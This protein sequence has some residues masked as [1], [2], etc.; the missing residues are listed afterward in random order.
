MKIM[1]KSFN[2]LVALAVAANVVSAQ[3][4]VGNGE[5]NNLRQVDS[6]MQQRG[7]TLFLNG[8]PKG[9]WSKQDLEQEYGEARWDIDGLTGPYRHSPVT[10]SEGETNTHRTYV[11][12]VVRSYDDDDWYYDDDE[13]KRSKK[14]P[15]NKDYEYVE[16]GDGENGKGYNT[17]DDDYYFEKG[18]KKMSKRA[19]KKAH[20]AIKKAKKEKKDKKGK[21]G[22]G[23]GSSDDECYYYDDDCMTIAEIA[24]ETEGFET[25]CGLVL[26]TGLGQALSEDILTVF[27]P[28]NDAF[29]ELGEDVLA[30]LT[31]EEVAFILQYHAVEDE[32]LS[33]DL[34]CEA[35]VEMSNGFFTETQCDDDGYIYQVGTGNTNSNR[36]L[37]VQVDIDACN[38]VVHV[39]D[40]VILPDPDEDYTRRKLP[41]YDDDD[42]YRKDSKGSKSGKSMKSSKSKKGKKDKKLCPRPPSGSPSEHPPSEDRP[43]DGPPSEPAPSPWTPAPTDSESTAVNL[44]PYALQYEPIDPRQPTRSELQAV[45]G[46]TQEYLEEFM[47]ERFSDDTFTILD[48]FIT[49][50]VTSSFFEEEEVIVVDYE[51]IG[52]FNPFSTVIPTRAQLNSALIDAFTGVDLLVYEDMLRD[53]LGSGNVF[54]NARV[55]F[56]FDDSPVRIADKSKLGITA[57]GIAAAAVA[58]TLLAAGAV[59]YTRRQKDDDDSMHKLNK[60]GGDA[61][62]AGETYAGETCDG[63]ASVSASSVEYARQIYSDDDLSTRRENLQSIPE[64]RNEPV[65]GRAAMNALG[66]PRSEDEVD[67]IDSLAGDEDENRAAWRKDVSSHRATNTRSSLGSFEDIALASPSLGGLESVRE[68]GSMSSSQDEAESQISESELSQFVSS[69][70]QT[71]ASKEGLSTLDIK[72]LLSFESA[73]GKTPSLTGGLSV[74]D[75]SGRRPRTIAEIEALLSADLDQTNTDG[76]SG[77]DKPSNNRPRTVQEIEKLL[78]ADLNVDSI[79]LTHDD[80]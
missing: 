33:D 5:T 70:D 53:Q 17:Y 76:A 10:N 20:D 27:A 18:D 42:H 35:E 2:L 57:T 38:G 37:V 1:M 78:T 65:F 67:E 79:Q 25:L 68:V 13:Y 32:I 69:T 19:K 54:S 59:I 71:P 61:T 44:R 40:N 34:V 4:G 31:L 39:V 30:S 43:S 47:F 23:K 8:P 51:S 22:K 26:E 16:P 36:P 60:N 28:T 11:G 29:E 6:T 75:N 46:V 73:D 49:L 24:C 56:L 45:T 15:G 58:F 62:V 50:L 63:S 3:R 55:T 48:D 41:S 72:S 21:G 7:R 74:R 77:N 52:R 80:E 9:D 14:R 64:K 12:N 66:K